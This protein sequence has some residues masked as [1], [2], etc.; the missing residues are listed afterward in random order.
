MAYRNRKTRKRTRRMKRRG[1]A[2]SRRRRGGSYME[3]LGRPFFAGV[4]PSSL[5]STYTSWT[6]AQPNNYPAPP[7]PENKS[8]E[9]SWNYTANGT[10]LN[11]DMISKIQSGFTLMSNRTL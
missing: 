5:Q 8:A 4:Y 10:P 9:H 1:L 3:A 11:P 7:P 6:G 2:F